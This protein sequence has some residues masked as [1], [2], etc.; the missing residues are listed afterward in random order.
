MKK[1]PIP[2]WLNEA[3]GYSSL[4]VGPSPL[5]SPHDR[6]FKGFVKTK[7]PDIENQT[8]PL[9]YFSGMLTMWSTLFVQWPHLS[10]RT[11]LYWVARLNTRHI[12]SN[13]KRP[14]KPFHMLSA[15]V[16]ALLDSGF[17]LPLSVPCPG[18]NR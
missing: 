18:A 12:L 3:T 13:I 16:V 8:K 4:R 5:H 1:G 6:L 9:L 10:P 11:I 17:L 15:V 7:E 2:A 14:L